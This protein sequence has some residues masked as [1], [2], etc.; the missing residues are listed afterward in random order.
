MI[1]TVLLLVTPKVSI[2]ILHHVGCFKNTSNVVT[3]IILGP[4]RKILND[5][6]GQFSGTGSDIIQRAK[7]L[8][9]GTS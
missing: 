7:S 4:F 1:K 6:G 5:L 8:K 2:D 3:I 9:T